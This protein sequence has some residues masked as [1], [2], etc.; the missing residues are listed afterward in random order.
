MKYLYDYEIME[1]NERLKESNFVVQIKTDLGTG[2]PNIIVNDK[3]D[4]S[5]LYRKAVTDN[6]TG[7]L[8]IQDPIIKFNMIFSIA[9]NR[10]DY[11]FDIFN[12]I[13]SDEVGTKF[14]FYKNNNECS[15]NI[16]F[17]E[18]IIKEK[19]ISEHNISDKKYTNFKYKFEGN[20]S[21]IILYVQFLEDTISFFNEIWAYTEKGEEVY[22]LKYPIGSIVSPLKDK[23]K[24]YFILD[25]NYIKEYKKYFIH[26]ITAMIV[27]T[28]HI[29][30]Y[31]E[32]IQFKEY[33]LGFSRNNRIDNILN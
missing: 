16:E 12:K 15:N 25:Y 11:F 9:S 13:S 20:L 1:W 2:E 5:M 10:V 33:E 17:T 28:G 22:L 4:T 19:K 6:S 27:S 8:G 21:S 32:V 31:G 7:R 3:I 24:D 29:I 18:K 14:V 23:S 26:Y 30:K